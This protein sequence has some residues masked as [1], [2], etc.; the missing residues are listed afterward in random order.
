MLLQ[1]AKQATANLE[2]TKIEE[3]IVLA[4][5]DET[6]EGCKNFMSLMLMDDGSMYRSP[7][8]EFDPHLDVVAM[9]YS[10][11][12]TGAPKGVCLTHYNLVANTCQMLSPHVTDV[13]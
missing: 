5:L 9:P 10:S 7:E 13:K 6:P 3:T 1:Q 8:D 4:G 12:T 2:A 11:G